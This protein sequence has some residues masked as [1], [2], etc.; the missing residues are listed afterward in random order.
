MTHDVRIITIIMYDI[1]FLKTF[2]VTNSGC[3]GT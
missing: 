1:L 2:F 3:G